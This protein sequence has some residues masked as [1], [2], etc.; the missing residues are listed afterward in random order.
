MDALLGRHQLFERMTSLD[1]SANRLGDASASDLADIVRG[2][3]NALRSLNLARN[4]FSA[5]GIRTLADALCDNTSIQ[6]RPAVPS[7][8]TAKC[9]A[10]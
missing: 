2:N 4:G 10:T 7:R 3:S 8:P 5:A 9:P 1:L 6:A